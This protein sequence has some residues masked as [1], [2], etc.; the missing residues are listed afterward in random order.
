MALGRWQAGSPV[1]HTITCTKIRFR[2]GY[3]VVILNLAPRSMCFFVREA[4][5]VALGQAA[6]IGV[7]RAREIFER[8]EQNAAAPVTH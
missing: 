4:V 6:R 2:F 7:G 5:A 3:L 1:F 8:L